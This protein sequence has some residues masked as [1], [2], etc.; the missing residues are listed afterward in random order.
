MVHRGWGAGQVVGATCGR[1]TR[2]TEQGGQ[3]PPLRAGMGIVPRIP[4]CHPEE[5]SPTKDPDGAGWDLSRHPDDVTL[6]RRRDPSPRLRM[7]ERGSHPRRAGCPHPAAL[8]QGQKAGRPVVAPF[9][10]SG[11]SQGRFCF[12]IGQLDVP[13]VDHITFAIVSISDSNDCPVRL[14]AQRVVVASSYSNDVPPTVHI[15]VIVF[16]KP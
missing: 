15:N 1:L 10:C 7:T 12:L 8:A 3:R 14:K 9:C 16:E 6:R 2:A 4:R 5:A 13:P 11:F